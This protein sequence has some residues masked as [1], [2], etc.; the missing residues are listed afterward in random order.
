MPQE[1]SSG[2]SL[3]SLIKLHLASLPLASS[4]SRVAVSSV[5]C[6]QNIYF[7]A[8][9]RGAPLTKNGSNQYQNGSSNHLA[10]YREQPR[11][12]RIVISSPWPLFSAA[13]RPHH[14]PVRYGQ[15]A[16]NSQGHTSYI[17]I[18]NGNIDVYGDG[19][20]ELGRLA[21]E[22]APSLPKPCASLKTPH[23]SCPFAA[24]CWPS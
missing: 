1:G 23:D 17:E 15:Q 7:S 3:F 10:P 12:T 13:K 24:A 11:L 2:F 16:H 19:S 21:Q 6:A 14:A 18:Q 4:Y 5:F 20:L 8:Q 22:P 9:T